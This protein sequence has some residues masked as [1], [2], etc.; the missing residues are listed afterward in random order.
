MK[1]SKNG[2]RQESEKEGG[3]MRKILRKKRMRERERERKRERNEGT[4]GKLENT[5]S[6]VSHVVLRY[7]L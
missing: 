7:L 4:C 3:I 1:K 6:L 5:P 2:E